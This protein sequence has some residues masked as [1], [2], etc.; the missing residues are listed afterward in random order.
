M[1]NLPVDLVSVPLNRGKKKLTSMPQFSSR[2]R[3]VTGTWP[4]KPQRAN[5]LL[6]DPIAPRLIELAEKL[7]DDAMRNDEEGRILSAQQGKAAPL[8]QLD[9]EARASG[10][11]VRPRPA[12]GGQQP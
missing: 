2:G 9:S 5:A 6:G 4:L 3:F 8:P 12:A 11:A 7:E 1:E 10:L